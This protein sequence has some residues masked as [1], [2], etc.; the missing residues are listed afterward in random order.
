MKSCRPGWSRLFRCCPKSSTR[1]DLRFWLLVL[2]PKT[3]FLLDLVAKHARSIDVF[4]LD[5]GRLPAETYRLMSEARDKY[6]VAIRVYCPDT[7][8]LEN[9][10]NQNG[11]DAFYRSIAQRKDCC[12]VRKVEPLGRALEGKKA[13]VTGLRRGQ[14]PTREDLSVNTFDEVHGLN[15]FSP[16]ARLDLGR[17]VRI[18]CEKRGSVQRASRPGIPQHRMRAVYPCC[19]FG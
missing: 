3:W 12:H 7:K 1:S 16:I 5:T 4:T 18:Y 19:R 6:P 8:A 13:W 9:Y 17:G 11:P 10:I 2:V 14:S 15:K